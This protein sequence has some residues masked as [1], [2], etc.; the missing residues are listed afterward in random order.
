MK[1]FSA[2]AAVILT[3]GGGLVS[4][5]AEAQSAFNV[6]VTTDYR[7]RGLSQSRL[8]P[9]LQGGGDFSSGPFYAGVWA[10]T[11][12]WV[13]DAG[14]KS[15]MEFDFYGGYKGELSK[16][17]S[18]DVGAAAYIYPRH[19][20]GISPDTVEIYGALTYGSMVVKYSHGL[21]NLFGF[22]DSKN[23]FYVEASTSL[24]LGDGFNLVPHVGYQKVSKNGD[25]SYVDYSIGLNKEIGGFVISAGLYGANTDSYIGKG[26]NLGK[27]GVS[28]GLKF[29]F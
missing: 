13:K 3:L 7:F 15:N 6:G 28:A 21:T 17:L 2:I 5:S 29:N 24:S 9:A 16:D 23:S 11:I 27:A 22:S 19:G 14:G 8:Q 25:A 10:S 20:L 18:Y 1:K 4:A 12:K 26:K